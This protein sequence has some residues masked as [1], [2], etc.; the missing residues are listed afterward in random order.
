M[1]VREGEM[2]TKICKLPHTSVLTFSL[3]LTQ[4]SLLP[5]LLQMHDTCAVSRALL[6]S[7]LDPPPQLIHA[8]IFC[9]AP[10]RQHLRVAGVPQVLQV[11][12][13]L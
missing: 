4:D 1:V 6:L 3:F 5:R 11:Q 12:V 7:L 13:G 9:G 10:D 8:A 2:Q